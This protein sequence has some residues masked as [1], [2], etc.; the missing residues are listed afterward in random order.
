[1]APIPV[2]SSN[3]VAPLP[4]PPLI[5]RQNSVPDFVKR[6]VNLADPR[7]GAKALFATDEFFAAKERMLSSEPAIFI[8]DKFDDNGKWMD[9]WETRRKR[10]LGY[11]YCVVKLGRPGVIHGVDINT[12]FFTG[13][14][15]PAASLDAC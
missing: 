14:F 12:S 3:N 8:P 6:Y 5:N 11:N 4:P 9:G 13:N 15:P 2:S 7:L 10:S 1:M